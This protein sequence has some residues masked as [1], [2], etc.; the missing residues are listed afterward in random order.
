MAFKEFGESPRFRLCKEELL[1]DR[2]QAQ[3]EESRIVGGLKSTTAPVGGHCLPPWP[4]VPLGRARN[5]DGLNEK[6]QKKIR[7]TNATRN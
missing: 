4:C 2:S 6:K 7:L 5:P 3:R 1:A